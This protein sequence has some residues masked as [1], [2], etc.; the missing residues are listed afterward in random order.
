MPRLLPTLT[1]LIAVATGAPA[2]EFAPEHDEFFFSILTAGFTSTPAV[3]VTER[4]KSASG[5]N[6]TYAWK[7][8]DK[9]GTQV[10]FNNLNGRAHTWGGWVWGV[11]LNGMTQEITPDGFEVNGADYGNGS[12]S[13]LTY[14]SFGAA[15]QVGY[16]Y[17]LVDEP[18]G[19]S[20]FLTIVPFYGLELTRAESEIRTAP[21]SLSYERS[22]GNGWGY[23]AGI[24]V[25]GYLT[26]KHWL[27]GVTIDARYGRSVT[28]IDFSDGSSSDLTITRS[29]VGFGLAGGYRF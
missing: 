20:G 7:D 18:D 14:R 13:T 28:S 1:A 25:G 12:D 6:T 21:G 5:V 23:D 26:E 11:E 2:A 16:Q 27:L 22:S 17:G 4:T 8:T 9:R 10:A 15:L 19:I 3:E 24:R 29:G